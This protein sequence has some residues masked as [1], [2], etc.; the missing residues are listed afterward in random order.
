MAYPGSLS[1]PPVICSSFTGRSFRTVP[2][3]SIRGRFIDT[4]SG[5]LDAP[6]RLPGGSH[7]SERITYNGKPLMRR[8]QTIY[9]YEVAR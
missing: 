1:L 9:A 2:I 3:E 5:P 7:L 4:A 6:E 8:A